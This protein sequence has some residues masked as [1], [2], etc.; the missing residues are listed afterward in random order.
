MGKKRIIRIQT[1]T[2][3]IKEILTYYAPLNVKFDCIYRNN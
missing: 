1:R 2:N 3:N